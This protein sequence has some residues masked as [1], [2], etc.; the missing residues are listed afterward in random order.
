ME[1][2]SR[3]WVRK[4][5]IVIMAILPK[6]IFTIQNNP[7]KIPAGFLWKSTSLLE[8]VHGNAKGQK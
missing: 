3:S 1:G 2:Y 8:N 6:L 7:I 4:V 5:N